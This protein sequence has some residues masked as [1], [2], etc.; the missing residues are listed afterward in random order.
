MQKC[1]AVLLTLVVGI[2]ALAVAACGSGSKTTSTGGGSSSTASTASN[3]PAIPLK[4]GE[5]ASQ[6]SLTPSGVKKGGTMTVLSSED[7]EH[8]DPGQAYFS[9]DYDVVYAMQ[10]PLL[11]YMPNSQTQLEPDLAT[12]VPSTSNGGVTDG[13][14]TI[15]VHIQP[16]VKYAPPVNRDVTSADVKY[17]IERLA[18]PNVLSGYFASYFEFIVGAKTAKGGNIS[19]ITT[20]NA[21]T[22][23]MKLTAPVSNIVIQALSLPGTAPVPESVVAP[24]DKSAPTK[25][26]VTELTATGPYMIQGEQS[27]NSITAGFNPSKSLTLVRNPNW[28]ASTYS[29]AYKPPAYL[30]QIN[31]QNGGSANVIGPQV[32]K[33]SNEVQLDTPSRGTVEQ[34]YEKYPSQITFTTGAGDHYLTL[35]NAHGIFT[36]VNIR[37]AVFANLDRQA[38]IKLKGGALTGEPGTGF[39]TPGTDGFTQSGG[40]AGP[41]YPWNTNTAGS[42]TTAEKYMKAAG[43]PS[44]KYTGSKTALIVGADDSTDVE[45]INQLVQKDFNELGIKTKLLQVD[46]S[47]MYEKYCT[48][49]KSDTDACPDGG[50]IR[51]FDNAYSILYPTFSSHVITPTLTENDG[52]VSDPTLDALM[53]KA[54]TTVSPTAAAEEWGKANDRIIEQA[55]AVPEDF[56]I[57]PNIF[58]SDV[59]WVGDLWN[60]GTVDL[61]YTGLK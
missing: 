54:Q 51:D 50:W 28:S 56:D 17:A 9:L 61:S 38:I 58:A 15:T 43:Y 3:T 18:N 1:K 32:L 46:Q 37:R 24:L 21:T 27:G 53:T 5:D 59:A 40:Y 33:G 57:Q 10:R 11:V 23:V 36:N 20:P 35:D 49:P 14:K 2:V 7:F 12:E 31:I 30:N 47:I 26:G 45:A 19:G 55:E 39:I 13:G 34:A 44:G 16:N 6:E 4:S 42:L 41:N 60:T 29:G 8:L 25:F 52:S 22:L 48:V